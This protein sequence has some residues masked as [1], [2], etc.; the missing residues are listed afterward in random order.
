M[1][2]KIQNLSGKTKKYDGFLEIITQLWLHASLEFWGEN[3]LQAV[4]NGWY[5]GATI[6]VA[7][8]ANA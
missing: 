1:G 2:A 5:D 3:H 8:V 4:V 7:G 6:V